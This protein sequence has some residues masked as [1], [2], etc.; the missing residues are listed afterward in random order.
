MYFVF[1]IASAA[2]TIQMFSLRT[3]ARLL[4]TISALESCL[5]QRTFVLAFDH[6]NATTLYLLRPVIGNN[7][8][9]RQSCGLQETSEV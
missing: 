6:A 9:V 5:A 3:V 4:F 1:D 7:C 2:A 8:I